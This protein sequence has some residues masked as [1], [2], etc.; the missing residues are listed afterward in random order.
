M[1]HYVLIYNVIV[2]DNLLEIC[3]Y[4]VVKVRLQGDHAKDEGLVQVLYK[5]EW[6]TI[7]CTYH[8]PQ[9]GRVI[10]RMLGYED[11]RIYRKVLTSSGRVW[12]MNVL[13]HG[14]EQSIAH[15]SHRGWGV[16][17]KCRSSRVFVTCK[18]EINDTGKT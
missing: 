17:Q 6:G 9:N 13:C 7:C 16:V 11:V 4:I 5:N 3:L 15:C 12:M 10:C 2:T 1:K 18:A 14:N 8:R